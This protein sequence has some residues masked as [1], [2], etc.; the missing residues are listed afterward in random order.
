[1]IT[2]GVI[3]TAGRQIKLTSE[4]W[5]LMLEDFL[6]FITEPCVLVTGGA[7]GADALAVAAYEKKP[8]LIEK[9]IWH[10]P[11]TAK[12]TKVM[13]HYWDKFKDIYDLYAV[14]EELLKKGVLEISRWILLASGLIRLCSSQVCFVPPSR[15]TLGFCVLNV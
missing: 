11:G 2:I 6:R 9:V 15:G 14:R 5:A 3:G 10:L 13:Y 7:A 4:N 1:M 12:D 8:D